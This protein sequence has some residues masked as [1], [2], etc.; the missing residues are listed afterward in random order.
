MFMLQVPSVQ[1]KLS[2]LEYEST[3]SEDLERILLDEILE[4][5]ERLNVS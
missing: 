3:V 2:I 5:F 1:R 4:S